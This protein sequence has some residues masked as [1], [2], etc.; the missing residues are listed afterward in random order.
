MRVDSPRRVI[1]RLITCL[2][3]AALLT[4]CQG[5]HT[6]PTP[7]SSAIP[8]KQQS[9][10]S[11]A[12]T[13]PD[14]ASGETQA[15]QEP[16]PSKIPTEKPAIEEAQNLG[17]GYVPFGHFLVKGGYDPKP[18]ISGE[19]T[20]YVIKEGL[21]DISAKKL[22]PALEIVNQSY[23]S[24]GS[25]E[26]PLLGGVIEYRQ[27]ASN[28]SPQK[29]VTK[30]VLI[31]TK[32][33][34]VIRDKE[35]LRE[36]A[37][38]HT[39]YNL[40]GSNSS[41]ASVTIF[42]PGS[43]VTTGYDFDT[44]EIL[45]QR[46]GMSKGEVLGAVAVQDVGKGT[47]RYTDEP[48]LKVTGTDVATGRSLYS[49]DYAELGNC[50]DVS[51]LNPFT[52]SY[53]PS[54]ESIRYIRYQGNETV[55]DFEATTGTP[56][57]LP[58]NASFFDLQSYLVVGADKYSPSAVTVSDCRTGQIKYTLDAELA[59]KLGAK[60]RRIYNGLLHISTTDENLMINLDTGLIAP[61]TASRYALSVID[62]W[63]YWSDGR[64]RKSIS[65]VGLES[66]QG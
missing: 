42:R 44:G 49:F 24:L 4:A 41:V 6:T 31:D 48:C 28:L 21:F 58:A 27:P 22:F 52:G 10:P 65:Q 1:A 20:I 54:G 16:S 9:V 57:T 50:R 39:A 32:Q 38:K 8:S 40:T 3:L 47:S 63:T 15:M 34:K 55:R 56:I 5:T 14:S 61:D 46:E 33:K 12:S 64:L 23:T 13:S 62:S 59:T 35:I 19:A 7:P 60:V 26:S 37:E 25:E 18:W 2:C 45:W 17:P 51:V 30:L 36:D 53:L 11:G 43:V 29:Y 66:D